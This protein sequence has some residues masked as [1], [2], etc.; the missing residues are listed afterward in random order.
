MF[1]LNP[2]QSSGVNTA[3]LSSLFNNV[4]DVVAS[5]LQAQNLTSQCTK[6]PP[7]ETALTQSAGLQGMIGSFAEA[8]KGLLSLVEKLVSSIISGTGGAQSVKS[9]AQTTDSTGEV[10]ATQS[11]TAK[12]EDKTNTCSSNSDNKIG[13][14]LQGISGILSI[15][16][17][18]AGAVT[19]VA[20]SLIAKS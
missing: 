11:S 17:P 12:A 8:L 2:A 7:T 10:K 6:L 15:F 20:G 5:P 18:V 14:I 9:T 1:N 16:F 13:E 19:G 4:G 3:T